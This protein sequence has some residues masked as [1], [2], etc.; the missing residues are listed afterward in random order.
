MTD[1]LLTVSAVND[2]IKLLMD[3][4]PLLSDLYIRGEISNFTNHYKTG[5]YYFSL[6]DETGTIRA[7]MFR[8]YTARLRFL[9]EN[10]M[11]VILHGRISVFPRD[12]QYQIYVDDMQPDG[13]GALALAFEQLRRKLEAEGLFDPAGKKS[14]PSYPA[15][16]GLITSPTGA[17][18]QD[19]I[20]ILGRR[21][22]AAEVLLYPALV[23]GAGAPESLVEG[24]RFFNR[25]C[26]V[27][28]LIIG[29]GGGSTEDLWAFNN[30][31]LAREVAASA[32]PVISAVGHETDVTICDFA[33]DL[34]APT[35]SAA[36]EIAVPDKNELS[37]HLAQHGN[38]I[39]MALHNKMIAARNR[40]DAMKNFRVLRSPHIYVEDRRMQ[41]LGL[42]GFLEKAERAK[43]EQAA[44]KLTG[45]CD[46][47][48]ALN[49]LS[50][51]GRGYAA[52]FDD[53][54]H[55]VSKGADLAV[56]DVIGIKFSDKIADARVIGIRE[57]EKQNEKHEI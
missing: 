41:V 5:H 40:V 39:R 35:P 15:R 48:A 33:A 7:V 34:R 57:G 29:R 51:L 25:H 17:A 14:L 22:P 4:N 53:Q 18:V 36:A 30:E 16:I 6:K 37:L 32:I 45:L 11:K 26:P 3:G 46:R 50:V 55:A 47:M 43:L 28:V 42:S 54:G 1:R 56:D 23:Q 12:G 13:L 10:G 27:D 21:F 44:N 20:H 9:P 19:M 8:S 38:L 24:V 52:V 49:P 2:Y 31:A